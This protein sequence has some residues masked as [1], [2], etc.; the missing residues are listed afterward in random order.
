MTGI[1]KS[2]DDRLNGTL[3][4]FEDEEGFS[5]AQADLTFADGTRLETVYFLDEAY[6]AVPPDAEEEQVE[7]ADL[8]VALTVTETST[9][10]T[11]EEDPD[12]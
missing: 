6:G 3:R 4:F 11:G 1:Y 2:T 5:Y 10:E 9:E 7:E 8:T 12:E